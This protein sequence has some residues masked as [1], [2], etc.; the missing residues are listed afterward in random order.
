VTDPRAADEIDRTAGG[1]SP[2]RELVVIDRR[3]T[4]RHLLPWAGAVVLGRARESDVAISHSSLSRRHAILHLHDAGLEVEDLGSSNGTRLR[5]QRIVPHVPTPFELGEAILIGDITIRVDRVAG[6]LRPRRI[7]PHDYFDAR[8]EEECLRA[9]RG[10]PVF[11]VIRVR[12]A[13]SDDDLRARDALTAVLRVYDVIGRYAEGELEVLLVDTPLDRA[14]ASAARIRRQLERAGIR[15]GVG[16]ATFPADGRSPDRLQDQS[17]MSAHGTAPAI[18]RAADPAAA[19]PMAQ[20]QLVVDRVAPTPIN[21]LILGETGVGK[22][23][24][25]ERI[26]H[27]SDRAQRPLLQINC[28]ALS[29][30]LLESELFGHERGAFTGAVQTKRGLLET[31]D[32]GTVFLDEIGEMPIALQAKLLR[33]IENRVVQRVGG[34]EPR[35]IDVRFLA[36]TNRNLEAEIERKGFRR[37]LYF[38]LAGA[39]IKI[40]P[41]RERISEIEALAHQFASRFAEEIGRGPIDISEDAMTLL[42]W[43]GW[44]GNIRELRNVIERAVILSHDDVITTEHLPVAKIR[45]TYTTPTHD[46]RTG[47]PRSHIRGDMTPRSRVPPRTATPSSSDHRASG[48]ARGEATVHDELQRLEHAADQLMRRRIQ[49][50]LAACSGN[51][52]Y[53]ARMLGISRG[54]LLKRIEK[55]GIGRPR[56]RRRATSS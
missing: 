14:E 44:P 20:I 56:K 43:Y 9:E 8:L 11:A 29:E 13:T 30:S 42:K 12:C 36:A 27:A 2:R 6:S 55:Y 34:L 48:L 17:A 15:A 50:A 7:W 46:A 10:G 47:T 18:V 1:D 33:V 49:E 54:T 25:A 5:G 4:T 51:Q 26:H 3:E 41:L 37:D 40:P 23:V 19:G 28:A 24:L 31:A 22:D 21:I 52:T 35:A 39:T 38:R 32:G 16:L 45:S 53:A